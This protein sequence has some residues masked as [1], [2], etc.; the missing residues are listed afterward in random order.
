[1]EAKL[2]REIRS[3]RW[4][5][6]VGLAWNLAAWPKQALARRLPSDPPA[7]DAADKELYTFVHG[8]V[9]APVIILFKFNYVAP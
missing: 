1:M 9:Y 8:S 4:M 5:I 7:P 2:S 3:Y 6:H